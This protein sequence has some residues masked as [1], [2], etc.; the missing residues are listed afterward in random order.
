MSEQNTHLS[1][2]TFVLIKD[3]QNLW[4]KKQVWRCHVHGNMHTD[5][6]KRNEK[7]LNNNHFCN[8]LNSSA[9]K[10]ADI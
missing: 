6:M 10:E 7:L 1:D 5:F 3:L 9:I 4:R 8:K 2:Y